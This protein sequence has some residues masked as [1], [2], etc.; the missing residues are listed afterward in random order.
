MNITDFELLYKK[1]FAIS[2]VPGIVSSPGVSNIKLF[3]AIMVDI[4][5]SFTKTF[6]KYLVF[7]FRSCM[8]CLNWVMI[9]L[10]I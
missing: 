3:S 7:G 9:L 4:F 10:K 1:K 2:G 8:V 6:A 5:L